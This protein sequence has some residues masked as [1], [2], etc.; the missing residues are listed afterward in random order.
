MFGTIQEK[1]IQNQK[2]TPDE[3][4]WLLAQVD[5]KSLT[6]TQL[7]GLLTGLIIQYNKMVPVIKEIRRKSCEQRD[8]GVC[9]EQWDVHLAS[10]GQGDCRG[11]WSTAGTCIKPSRA[12]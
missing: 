6:A 3:V 4:M 1:V 5:A 10:T 9:P 12:V 11:S 8:A 2:V 7:G